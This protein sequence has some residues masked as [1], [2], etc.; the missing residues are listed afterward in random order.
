MTSFTFS[1]A[2]LLAAPPEVRRWAEQEIG[3]A[4]AELSRHLQP[5]GMILPYHAAGEFPL[6]HAALQQPLLPGAVPAVPPVAAAS[7]TAAGQ[8][9]T[10]TSTHEH[11]PD[12][13]G[14]A[15]DQQAD[16]QQTPAI[17]ACTA[18]EAVRLFGLLEDDLPTAQVFFEFGRETASRLPDQPLCA[19]AIGD[20]MRHARL[21][22]GRQLLT[23]LKR[24]NAAF[25]QLR[26]AADLSLFGID[27]NGYLYLHETTHQSIHRLWADLLTLEAE[28]HPHAIE[29]GQARDAKTSA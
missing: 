20:I 23:C 1:L 3:A 13:R 9:A 18:D 5:R 7:G 28:K 21:S 27:G 8:Q 14:E 16:S 26:D 10:A 6:R 15:G 2:Q 4:L 19:Y 12:R 17:A 22:D 11:E 24:I 25:Q 29:M